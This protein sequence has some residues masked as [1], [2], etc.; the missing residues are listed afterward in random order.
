MYK[1]TVLNSVTDKETPDWLINLWLLNK[2]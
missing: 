2:D 1:I